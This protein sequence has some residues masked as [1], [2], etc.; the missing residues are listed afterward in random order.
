M[1]DRPRGYSAELRIFRS[2]SPATTWAPTTRW[3]ALPAEKEAVRAARVETMQL[4][5]PLAL[6]GRQYVTDSLPR[7]FDVRADARL[8]LAAHAFAFGDALVHDFADTLALF[9]GQ[10]EVLCHAFPETVVSRSARTERWTDRSG[11]LVIEVQRQGP[12]QQSHEKQADHTG[13]GRHAAHDFWIEPSAYQAPVGARVTIRFRVGEHFRGDALP[14]EPRRII[15]FTHFGP[16]SEAPVGGIEGVDPVGFV[17]LEQPGLHLIAYHS[18]SS[19]VELDAAQFER[20]LSE[21]GLDRIIEERTRRDETETIGKERFSR[22]VKSLLRA[23]D[24]GS[25]A[26]F[27]RIVG[28]PVELVPEKNP[29]ELAAG[30][31]LPVR[32]LREGQPLEGVLVVG[33]PDGQLGHAV[34]GRT[35]AQ[36]RVLL[37]LKQPGAWLIKA[38]HME[39]LEDDR[40]DWQSWWASLT[41]RLLD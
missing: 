2:C 14:R 24:P 33:Y 35:D 41:F 38:V 7:L 19:F 5:E 13:P 37:T 16:G 32:M 17:R 25:G 8:D 28:L 11:P 6:L 9:I 1:L 34:R 40:A 26:G 18:T 29:Y 21:E 39:R 22:C 36:G 4:F 30:E 23:G 10:V 27:D 3:T 12:R 20:Y 31:E 15:A